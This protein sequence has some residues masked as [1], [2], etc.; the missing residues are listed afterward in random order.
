MSPYL[1]KPRV[2]SFEGSQV[3]NAVRVYLLRYRLFFPVNIHLAMGTDV[4]HYL[5]GYNAM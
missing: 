2:D 1:R 4:E 5:V 3:D